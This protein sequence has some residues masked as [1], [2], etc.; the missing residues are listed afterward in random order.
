M[1]ARKV[2][3]RLTLIP[4]L[5][6]AFCV[7]VRGVSVPIGVATEWRF[8]ITNQL[9][10]SAVDLRRV[11]WI[12]GEIPMI[13][14]RLAIVG[15]NFLVRQPMPTVSRRLVRMDGILAF[16]AREGTMTVPRRV[17]TV[18][19]LAFRPIARRAPIVIATS[20]SIAAAR[21]SRRVSTRRAAVARP[22]RATAARRW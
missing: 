1:V 5:I 16:A 4:N 20:G 17:V 19:G 9:G 2:H 10:N 15:I 12:V 13:V 11:D 21:L 6:K 22:M 3:P 7:L 18:R 14:Q 8:G